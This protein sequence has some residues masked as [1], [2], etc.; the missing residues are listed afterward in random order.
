[1]LLVCPYPIGQKPN[2]KPP[3]PQN[4]SRKQMLGDAES[5]DKN[6]RSK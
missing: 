4:E 5:E 2:R 1:V 3:D 6:H